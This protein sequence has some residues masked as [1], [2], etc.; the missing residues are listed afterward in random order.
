MHAVEEFANY[1]RKSPELMGAEEV[2]KF[3]LYRMREKKLALG[4]VPLRM[5]AL[6]FL[7]K[8]T[9]PP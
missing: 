7:Y 8:K 1:F 5:G 2:R 4:T 9:A 3:Q 6:R